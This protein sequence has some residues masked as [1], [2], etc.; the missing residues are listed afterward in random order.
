MRVIFTA[1]TGVSSKEFLDRFLE[2]SKERSVNT[3]LFHIGPMMYEL[4]KTVLPGRILKLHPSRLRTLRQLA[5]ERILSEGTSQN[6]FIDTHATFWWKGGMFFGFDLDHLKRFNADLY[7]TLI[8]DADT[9]FVRWREQAEATNTITL[10]DVLV[11][12]DCEINTTSLLALIHSKPHYLLATSHPFE[13]L[14]GLLS[15]P[16]RKRAYAS[17]PITAIRDQPELVKEVEDFKEKLMMHLILFDP[18]KIKEGRLSVILQSAL[19][20]DPKAETIELEILGE[21]HQFDVGE[22]KAA[23][24]LIK[25]QIIS[26]DLRLIDQSDMVVAYFPVAFERIVDSPGAQRELDHAYY[27]GKDVFVVCSEPDLLSVWVTERAT[28]VFST[29]EETVTGLRNRGLVSGD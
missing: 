3:E 22:L 5:F 4:D 2:S 8:D 17:F 16:N 7:I 24:H 11:W 9:T 18:H 25:N 15:C 27:T 26:R 23:I 10:S 19:A 14:S 21:N 20:E 28:E 13:V 6:I 12:R 1:Q 29:F